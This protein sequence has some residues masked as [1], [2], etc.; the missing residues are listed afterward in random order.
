MSFTDALICILFATL[1]GCYGWGMRGALIGGEKGAML[2]GA[3]IGLALS[4]FAGHCGGVGVIAAGLMGMTHGGIEPYGETIG[5][6]LHNPKGDKNRIKGFIGLAFKGAL[7]FSICGGFMAMALSYG[8]YSHDDI[9]IFCI[10]IPVIQLLGY[11]VFN[12][13]FDKEKGICPKISFSPTRREEW[14]S[15]LLLLVAMLVMAIIRKDSLAL[16]MISFGF[17]FGAIGWIVAIKCFDVTIKPMKN[18]QY[19]FGKLYERYMIDGWKIM[20]FVLG[21]F[22]GFGLSLAF[23]VGYKYINIYNNRI[24]LDGVEYF[25][26]HTEELIPIIC[27]LCVAG[28]FVINFVSFICDRRNV[29]ISS[30][31]LDRIERVFYS[32]I[33]MMFVLW[34]EIY[35]AMFMTAFMLVFVVVIKLVFDRFEKVNAISMIISLVIIAASYIYFVLYGVTDFKIIFAGTVPYIAG[36]LIYSMVERKQKG[37]SV[38]SLFTETAVAT[39]IPAFI[40]MSILIYI[41]AIKIF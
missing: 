34:G 37:H 21:A 14:G 29:K 32:V 5:L 22:G 9:K 31:V 7:W 1:A 24:S 11:F 35:S 13:P 8:V 20:E 27:G 28:V 38:K 36:E 3:F 16:L 30:F 41:S 33:P 17:V 23:C 18:G 6:V 10:L 19:I 2:P 39:V 4:A 26:E 12:T 15:N 25:N 40:V